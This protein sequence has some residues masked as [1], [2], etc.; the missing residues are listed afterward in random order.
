MA[1]IRFCD[2][3]FST[4]G[5]VSASGS[6]SGFPYTNAAN[7]LR[8]RCWR[9]AGTFY[10]TTSNRTLYIND[11]S[12][13]TVTLTVGTYTY[14]T[15]ASHIQTKLNASSSGWTCTYDFNGGTFKFTIGRGAGGTL[16]FTQTSNAAWD[17]LGYTL[18]ADTAGTS[19][20]AQ[21]S[22]N[23]TAERYEWTLPAAMTP[24]F[25]GAIGPKGQPFS[26]SETA[27]CTLKA[28]GMP[29]WDSPAATVSLD[30]R[31]RGIMR[32]LD[33][34]SDMLYTNF[35]FEVIDRTNPCGPEGFEFGR[36]WLGD[37]VT[38]TTTNVGTGFTALHRDPSDILE[39][40]GG[41]RFVNRRPKYREFSGLEIRHLTATE[42]LELEAVFDRL[43][44]G[45]HFFASLDPGLD[46]SSTLEELTFYALFDRDPDLRHVIRDI[47]T[48]SFSLKEAC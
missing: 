32:F 26:V 30:V 43:G 22:R 34:Q 17:M 11:G 6:A 16:R 46:V 19:F 27:T 1:N 24:T 28:N 3:D 45:G 10:V 5:T 4:I 47:Y 9:T 31:D 13:V 29:V 8:S 7:D 23:H 2:N 25:F 15:L 12:N 44:R 18:A 37:H 35:C 14:S 39:G 20:V 48:M 38:V 36:I 21:E 40:D 33:D 41:G 42:R